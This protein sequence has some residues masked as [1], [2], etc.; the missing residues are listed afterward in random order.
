MAFGQTEEVD[1]KLDPTL[2]G[3]TTGYINDGVCAVLDALWNWRMVQRIAKAVVIA[4]F[5]IF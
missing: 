5:L 3:G 1:V 4:L 2:L